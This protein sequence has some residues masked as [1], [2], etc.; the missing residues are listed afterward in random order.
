MQ[1]P[2]TVAANF[3][4]ILLNKR[5]AQP[6]H[7]TYPMSNLYDYDDGNVDISMLLLNHGRGECQQL[8]TFSIERMSAGCWYKVE[9][10]P[11][12][13]AVCTRP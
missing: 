2:F 10:V 11:Q 7:D 6:V 12:Q 3:V 5:C 8:Q 1:F 13:P 9:T 4:L